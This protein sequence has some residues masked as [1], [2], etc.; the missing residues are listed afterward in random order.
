MNKVIFLGRFVTDPEFSM[1]QSGMAI[2][3]FRIAVDRACTKQGDDKKSDFFQI[4][5][6]GKTAEFV[7]KYFCKGKPCMIEGKIQ[8]NNYT[9]RDGKTR[10]QDQIIADNVSFTLSDTTKGQNQQQYSQNDSQNDF[11]GMF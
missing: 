10:Y 7:N 9:D 1:N 5:T 8:N 6:F 11:T 4:A 3:K 2:C